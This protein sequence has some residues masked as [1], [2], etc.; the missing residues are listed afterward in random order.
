MKVRDVLLL[1]G[2]GFSAGIWKDFAAR[3]A[4]RFRVHVPDL[5]GYGATPACVPRSGCLP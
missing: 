4:P 3:L 5:P 2:W 1:H